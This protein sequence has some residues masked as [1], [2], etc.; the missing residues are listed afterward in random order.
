M[1]VVAGDIA[2]ISCRAAVELIDIH[3]LQI[4][5]R[6]LGR[7]LTTLFLLKAG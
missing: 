5:K 4:K 2:G 1:V 6:R 3:P 7:V